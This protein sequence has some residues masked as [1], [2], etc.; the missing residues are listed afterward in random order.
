[1]AISEE[2]QQELS[3]GDYKRIAS[4]YSHKNQ[5]SIT[6]SYVSMV[7]KG[8]R[9]NEEIVEI[10]ELYLESIRDLKRQLRPL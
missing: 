9:N 4:L 10:A 1:M 7:I 2:L 5:K 8:E 6:S 3:I